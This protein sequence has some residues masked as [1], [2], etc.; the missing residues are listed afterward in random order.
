MA[1]PVGPDG[2]SPLARPPPPA[3]R[4]TAPPSLSPRSRP[5]SAPWGAR[6]DEPGRLGTRKPHHTT[7]C[8]ARVSLCTR[9]RQVAAQRQPRRPTRTTPRRLPTRKKRKSAAPR[10]GGGPPGRIRAQSVQPRPELHGG[11]SRGQPLLGWAYASGHSVP[12]GMTSRGRG[13]HG[14]DEPVPPHLPTIIPWSADI[15][16][17]AAAEIQQPRPRDADGPHTLHVPRCDAAAPL[18]SPVPESLAQE[19]SHLP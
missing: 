18:G 6:G 4:V 17:V 3:R 11:T 16:A 5:R 1:R 12:R 19:Q 10:P 7:P 14:L 13:T 8:M 15:A 2:R 9:A